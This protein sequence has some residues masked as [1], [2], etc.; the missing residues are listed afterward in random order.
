MPTWSIPRSLSE[1]G[2]VGWFQDR[3]ADPPLR[4][5]RHR[6]LH[7]EAGGRFD[8]LDV[9]L[10]V[11]LLLT[12]LGLRTFRLAEPLQM[13]FDEVYHARTATEFLQAWRYGESHDIY[14][15]THPHLAKYAMAWGIRLAGGNE[16][17]DEDDLGVA[18]RDAVIE[19]RWTPERDP[20]GRYG[21][22][23]YLA[24][25]RIDSCACLSCGARW[26]EDAESGAF[27]GRATRS[28]VLAPRER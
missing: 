20:S 15:W 4:A 14:E 6:E 25:L 3:A 21:D 11:V 1:A 22:R 12:T 13:H 8:R 27:R 26:D 10:M 24:T 28:S 23:L 19:R 18:V 2:I 17:I 9:W 7:R 16:V 5:D